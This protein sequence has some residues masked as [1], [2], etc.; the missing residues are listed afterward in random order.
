METTYNSPFRIELIARIL[1]PT[2]VALVVYATLWVASLFD[3]PPG[4]SLPVVLGFIAFVVFL[5]EAIRLYSKRLERRWPWHA[6]ASGRLL[7]QLSGSVAIAI[8]CAL[9]IYVPLKLLEI[10]NG[11]H[12]EL[13]WPHLAVTSLIALVF[14]FALNALYVTLDFYASWQSAQRDARQLEGL[15]LRAELDALKSQINPHFLFNS[16]NTVQ[17]LIPREAIA[18]RALIVELSDVMRYALTHG[19]RDLVPLAQELEFLEAYRALLE[20]RHGAGIRIEIEPMTGAGQW[21]IPPM[22]LQVLVENAVRHNSTREEN[23]LVVKLRRDHTCMEVSNPIMPRHSANPG[24]GTGLANLDQRY[25]LL[26]AEGIHISQD[27][28]FFTVKVGLL[29]CAR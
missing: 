13:G 18:A 5:S 22:S 9:L 14:A 21:Q 2:V 16:L 25:R 17:G 29:S 19:S 6:R 8:G 10:H 23:P 12:D 26:G 1:Y 27:N 4:L 24:A 3:E 7:R 15:I 28:G 20:A 11:A